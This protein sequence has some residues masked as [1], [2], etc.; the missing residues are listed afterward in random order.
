MS[1]ASSRGEPADHICL[2][3]SVIILTVLALSLGDALIKITSGSFVIWQ[4][5]VIRSLLAIP[6]LLL[7]LIATSPERLQFQD[8]LGWVLLRSLMLV[9]MWICYYLALP[10]LT[11]SVA[12]A[13]YYTLPIFITLFSAI[14]IGERISGLGWIAVF[15]GFLGVLLIF[16]P[17]AG[18][19]NEYTILPIVAAMLYAGAMI[20]TRTRCRKQHPIVLALA[21]NICFVIVGALAAGGGQSTARCRAAWLFV[22]TVGC[23]GAGR[24]DFDWTTDSSSTYRQHR[25]SCRLSEWTA[26]R[27]RNFRFCVC[28]VRRNLGNDFLCRGARCNLDARYNPYRGSRHSVFEAM[29]ALPALPSFSSRNTNGS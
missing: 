26:I 4:I 15:A 10:R 13:S 1:K 16:R 14:F 24:M 5:F 8:V 21:L 29:T 28:G 18:D 11:L 12:A 19:F 25:G 9:G 20:L 22:G 7:L 2:A 3:V 27:D 6:V 23:D 17:S